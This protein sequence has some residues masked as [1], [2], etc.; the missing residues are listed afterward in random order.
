[1]EASRS[2]RFPPPIDT[3]LFPIR[4]RPLP[5]IRLVV[6]RIAIEVARISRC[7]DGRH[8]RRHYFPLNNR[9]PIHTSKPL[10][11]LD[12]RGA[13]LQVSV[14]FCQVG[15]KQAFEQILCVW[16]KVR[17]PFD[18]AGQDLFVEAVVIFVVERRV[19]SEHFKDEDAKG[20]PV[21]C[22]TVAF[23]LDD[24]RS[25]IIGSTAELERMQRN[26]WSGMQKPLR[27]ASSPRY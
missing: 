1:M 26:K 4:V 22:A 6:L 7:L 16:V 27:L 11:S 3:H 8:I 23:G 10:V 17:R 18:F 24:F 9:I 20:V 2:S 15:G 25:E 12:I 14:A 19:T 21:D 13:A 5:A